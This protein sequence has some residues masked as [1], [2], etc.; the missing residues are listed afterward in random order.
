MRTENIADIDQTYLNQCIN[1]NQI[2]IPKHSVITTNQK[3]NSIID[4][5]SE[6]YILPCRVKFLEYTF[7]FFQNLNQYLFEIPKTS[8]LV[9]GFIS[10]ERENKQLNLIRATFN[11]TYH[12]IIHKTLQD[13]QKKKHTQ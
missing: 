10:I 7:Q 12:S 11:Y 4:F 13:K 3:T 1:I 2:H 5:D 6:K 9:L 8:G